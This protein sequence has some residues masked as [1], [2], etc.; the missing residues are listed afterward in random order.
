MASGKTLGNAVKRNRAKRRMRE[1]LRLSALA[2]ELKP[3]QY[4]LVGRGPILT[5]DFA[6]LQNELRLC[7]KKLS[8]G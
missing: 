1:L 8:S 2:N 5:M 3:G 4:V 7:L 6:E